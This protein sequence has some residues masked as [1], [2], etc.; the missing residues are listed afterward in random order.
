MPNLNAALACAQ[1][2]QLDSFIKNKNPLIALL[3]IATSFIQIL[4]Y[5]TG[6]FVA[7]LSH[8]FKHLQLAKIKDKKD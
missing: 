7:M 4:S 2:E 5:G 1:L 6:F 8:F 3:S